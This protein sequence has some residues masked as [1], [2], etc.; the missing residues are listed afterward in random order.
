MRTALLLAVSLLVSTP[1]GSAQIDVGKKAPDAQW[2]TVFESDPQSLVECKGKLVLLYF[3]A[4]S[5]VQDKVKIARFNGWY[6]LF[7]KRGLLLICVFKQKADILEKWVDDRKIEF[8]L[9]SGREVYEKFGVKLL[10]SY[11]LVSGKGRILARDWGEEPKRKMLEHFLATHVAPLV[12]PKGKPYQKIQVAWNKMH[13]GEVSVL[14]ATALGETK[15]EAVLAELK[16]AQGVLQGQMLNVGEELTTLAKGPDYWAAYNRCLEIEKQ[17]KGLSLAAKAKKIRTGFRSDRR[18]MKEMKAIQ[19]LRRI[20]KRYDIAKHP[21]KKAR[22]RE[23]LRKFIAKHPGSGASRLAKD[24]L[25][26]IL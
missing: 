11:Y 4:P 19:E 9:V 7:K 3:M 20:E 14:I 18:I 23:K 13:F 5:E 21:D 10:P 24:V 6:E 26:E 22:L 16:K 25:D 17:F 2:E 12:L 1:W 15:D 8:P